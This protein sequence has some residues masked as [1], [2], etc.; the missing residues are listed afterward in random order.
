[1][2]SYPSKT[3]QSD[4]LDPGEQGVCHTDSYVT[5]GPREGPGLGRFPNL[6]LRVADSFEYQDRRGI[7]LSASQQRGIDCRESREHI[8]GSHVWEGPLYLHI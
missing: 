8:G 4:S 7:A 6:D 5:L 1:M 3:C 2:M